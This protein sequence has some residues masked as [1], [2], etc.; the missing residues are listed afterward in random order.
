[1]HGSNGPSVIT[2]KLRGEE[3]TYVAAT[4]YKTTPN[5]KLYTPLRCSSRHHFR[6]LLFMPQ[7]LL[8][9]LN[10]VKRLSIALQGLSM[11]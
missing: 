5:K 7:K 1:M 2:I 6:M 10:V 3:N 8:L 11:V 4:L 9:L